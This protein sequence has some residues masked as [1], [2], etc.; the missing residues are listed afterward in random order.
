MKS[1]N[2]AGVVVP[3]PS[4]VWKH[5]IISVESSGWNPMVGVLAA[6]RKTPTVAVTEPSAV[7]KDRSTVAVTEPPAGAKDRSTVKDRRRPAG[8]VV[9]D[10]ASVAA[11]KHIYETNGPGN[12]DWDF[13][14]AGQVTAHDGSLKAPKE[15]LTGL[16]LNQVGL[17]GVLRVRDVVTLATLDAGN[18]DLNGIDFKNL[19]GL[20]NLALDNNQ[21]SDLRP[22]TGLTALKGLTV[23]HNRIVDFAPVAGLTGLTRLDLLH[24]AKNAALRPLAGLASLRDTDSKRLR[25]LLKIEE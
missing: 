22:L 13:S 17:K 6:K 23:S 16:N 10:P 15:A 24:N 3:K 11:L 18:N 12:L 14:V 1:K 2:P 8:V 5:I 9:T 21:I 7:A 20:T 4:A 19:P 25:R